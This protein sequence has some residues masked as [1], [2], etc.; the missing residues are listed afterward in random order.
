[1]QHTDGFCRITHLFATLS[2]VHTLYHA[3]CYAASLVAALTVGWTLFYVDLVPGIVEFVLMLSAYVFCSP[4]T[5]GTVAG[6]LKS[7]GTAYGLAWV[8]HFVFEHNKPATLTY[9][10]FSFLGDFRMFAEIVTG[11]IPLFEKKPQKVE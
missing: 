1:M 11:R 2:I 7:L 9:P 4:L 5:G 3:P 8:G 10:A 6:A